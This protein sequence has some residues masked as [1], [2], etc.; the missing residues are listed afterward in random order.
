MPKIFFITLLR[1]LKNQIK[2]G[3]IPTP[4]MIKLRVK[5]ITS[6]FFNQKETKLCKKILK[7]AAR[8]TIKKTGGFLKN[9]IN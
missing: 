7:M 8:K 4:I 1:R 5:N 2:N 6:S 9:F 3:T